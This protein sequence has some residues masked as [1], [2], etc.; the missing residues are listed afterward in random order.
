MTEHPK[1][2][3]LAAR[4]LDGDGVD[5]SNEDTDGNASPGV[6]RQLRLVESIARTLRAQSTGDDRGAL[7]QSL[8]DTV[9]RLL[10]SAAPA[11]APERWGSLSIEGELGAGSFATVY[12]AWDPNLERPCA[13]KLF[14][15]TDPD[16]QQ[17][18][19]D[20]GRRLARIDHPGVVRVYGA[21][22][23]DG[24]VGLWME[25]IDGPTLADLLSAH[26]PMAE[27][28]AAATGRELCDAVAAV[29]AAGI[30]HGDIKAQNVMRRPDGRL[31]LTD[32]G[33]GADRDRPGEASLQGT[34]LY[35]APE[36]LDG[37]PPDASA[38]IYALGVLLFH[39]VTGA[40][41]VEADDI[42]ALKAA[43]K[44]SPKQSLR[45]LAPGVSEGFRTTVECALAASPT[46]RYPG[47]GGLA[48]ALDGVLGQAVN[49]EFHSA[50]PRWRRLL[51]ATAVIA[52]LAA[53]AAWLAPSP[54]PS[55]EWALELELYRSGESGAPVPLADGD[56]V[57]QGDRL[58]LELSA[59]E[60]VWVY[61]VN[62]DDRGN[63]FVLFP[64]AEAGHRLPLA[65]GRAHR[66]PGGERA[67]LAW[68]ID[69]PA[70]LE[71]IHVVASPEPLPD[72]S[73]SLATL[74][75]ASLALPGGLSVRGMG[76]VVPAESHPGAPAR[77]FVQAARRAGGAEAPVRGVQY[78]VIE[79]SHGD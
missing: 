76:A 31:V 43:H 45:D 3:Q 8:E 29:H 72:A 48:D 50:S 51:F 49:P 56:R 18:L 22:A 28:V 58:T 36:R 42:E 64:L 54:A 37:S 13:L 60:D 12:R 34:P 63:A 14:H 25:L 59:S 6:V 10:S 69:R 75:A 78:R 38:D 55:P 17:A 19:L 74:P 71:R 9:N 1:L 27:R 47:M 33:S 24:R 16:R 61:I 62:E 77:A 35:L 23:H 44:R 21:E 2:E 39:L 4:I 11:D 70:G 52:A 68:I 20:E 57:R 7:Q 30:V 73:A 5:W 15:S 26:G 53:G 65:G 67:D 79:L 40:W 41:P 32:F 66:L 46:E